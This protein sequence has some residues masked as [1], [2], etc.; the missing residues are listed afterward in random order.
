[1]LEPCGPQSRFRNS[2]QGHLRLGY[3]PLFLF[4]RAK[5]VRRHRCRLCL[6]SN[7]HSMVVLEERPTAS[8]PCAWHTDGRVFLMCPQCPFLRNTLLLLGPGVVVGAVDPETP[9]CATL[10]PRRLVQ[11]HRPL[12]KRHIIRQEL[13]KA[14]DNSMCSGHTALDDWRTRKLFSSDGPLPNDIELVLYY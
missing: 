10:V 7:P 6:P 4:L 5:I 13:C 8:L 14:A 3:I 2:N 9:F 1:V 12:S 11:R